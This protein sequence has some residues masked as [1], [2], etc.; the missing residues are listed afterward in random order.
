MKAFTDFALKNGYKCS[1]SVKDKLAEID[2]SID[3]KFVCIIF[4]VIYFNKTVFW[5]RPEVDVI[6]MFKMV[7]LQQRNG[8]SD[9]E[10][11]K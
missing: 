9:F 6:I 8:L 10:I 2:P 4:E 1:Q 11:E 7:V 5:G 3:W